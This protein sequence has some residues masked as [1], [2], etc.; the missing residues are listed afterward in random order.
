MEKPNP[1]AR[2]EYFSQRVRR[3]NRG[4]SKEAIGQLASAIGFE[5]PPEMVAVLSYANGGRVCDFSFFGVVD[6]NAAF[7]SPKV[8]DILSKWRTL[9]SLKNLTAEWPSTWVPIGYNGF[10]DIYVLDS[11]SLVLIP[12]G[13]IL[14]LDHEFVGEEDAHS[15]FAI[16][17]FSFL[18]KVLDELQMVWT[19]DGRIR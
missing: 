8:R 3:L 6:P 13:S 5:P 10:G 11:A 19:P 16:G 9:R 4:A 2:A 17:Y 7:R 18:E 1:L 15:Q 12:E 14:L